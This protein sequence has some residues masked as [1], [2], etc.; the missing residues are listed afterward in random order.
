[1]IATVNVS[2]VCPWYV[3][4]LGIEKRYTTIACHFYL[5]VAARV[6]SENALPHAVMIFDV[7]GLV[8]TTITP[9]TVT[10]AAK[11]SKT[12]AIDIC[13]LLTMLRFWRRIRVNPG[14]V[15]ATIP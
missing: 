9:A 12:R 2:S 8:T 7:L 3:S 5:P 13:I 14:T 1:M 11:I 6:L 15:R 10:S 4:V